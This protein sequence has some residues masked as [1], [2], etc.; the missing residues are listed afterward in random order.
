MK[1]T[2]SEELL[3]THKS[4]LVVSTDFDEE[5]YEFVANVRLKRSDIRLCRLEDGLYGSLMSVV[6][7]KDFVIN[8]GEYCKRCHNSHCTECIV[9][10]NMASYILKEGVAKVSEVFKMQFPNKIYK[11]DKAVQQ[12]LQLPVV[13]AYGIEGSAGKPSNVDGK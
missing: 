2:T 13:I 3:D 4:L 10:I 6:S 9:L 8:C 5:K 12:L 7:L 11:S 1:R